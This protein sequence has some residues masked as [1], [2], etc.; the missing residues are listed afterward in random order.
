MGTEMAYPLSP[1]RYTIGRR[2]RHAMFSDSQNS[3]SLV[4]PSPDV[5]SV[6]SWLEPSMNCAASAQP[7][8][9]RNCVPV[10]DDELT[11]LN[12][13]CP[14]CDGIWRPPDAG[15]SAAP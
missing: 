4:A 9:C 3:P 13:R 10:G 15:S 1:T 6:T 11:M 14:Q 2:F 8:A 7:A 12:L 5:T